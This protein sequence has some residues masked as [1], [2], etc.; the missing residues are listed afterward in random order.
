MIIEFGGFMKILIIRD[1]S[2]E[3]FLEVIRPK[4]NKV[5]AIVI[6]FCFFNKIN[7]SKEISGLDDQIKQLVKLSKECNCVLISGAECNLFEKKFNA[8]Y[9]L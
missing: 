8:Y 2:Y 6:N 4:I 3:N 1:S 9:S 7:Y 5:D